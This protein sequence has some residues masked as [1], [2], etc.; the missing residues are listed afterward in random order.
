MQL[1]NLKKIVQIYGLERIALFSAAMKDNG[2]K[3]LF[4]QLDGETK[5]EI[6]SIILTIKAPVTVYYASEGRKQGKFPPPQVILSWVKDHNIQFR[7]KKGR[8]IKDAATAFIVSRKIATVGTKLNAIHFLDEWKL[9]DEFKTD[10]LQAYIE[11]V[12]TELS[13]IIDKLNADQ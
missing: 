1:D 3:H 5:E 9:T 2:S 6:D 11:D 8:Y 12:K 4:D 10:A 13:Q 7:D